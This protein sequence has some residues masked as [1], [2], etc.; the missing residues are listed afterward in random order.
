MTDEKRLHEDIVVFGATWCRDCKR[1]KQFLGDQRVHYHWVNLEED[2]E[3]MAY[4]ETVNRG[5][6]KI[7]TIVFPDGANL[8]EPSN[9]ALA[10]QLGLTTRAERTFYDVTI[11][12]GGPAGL[13]AAI[14]AAREGLEAQVIAN[15]PPVTG[16]RG[17]ARAPDG[18]CVSATD[19]PPRWQG[20]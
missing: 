10:Q 1:S 9:A 8:A 5:Q 12:G 6:R 3:A 7:P 14:Y 2:S 15:G 20:T 17:G 13:T 11:V 16:E 19:V 18:G 4:V